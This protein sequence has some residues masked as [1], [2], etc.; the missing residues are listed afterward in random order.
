MKNLCDATVYRMMEACLSAAPRHEY[1]ASVS[2]QSSSTAFGF[3]ACAEQAK[4]RDIKK[5]CAAAHRAIDAH[6]KASGQSQLAANSAA[7]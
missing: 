6:C 1:C 7:E 2:S 4:S 5:A 3:D